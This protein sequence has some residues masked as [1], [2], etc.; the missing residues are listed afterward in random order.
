[1]EDSE[2]ILKLEKDVAEHTEVLQVLA[3]DR[4]AL[5]AVVRALAEANSDNPAFQQHLKAQV[6]LRASHQLNSTMTDGQIALFKE[7]LNA[8]LPPKLRDI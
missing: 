2:K 1:M 5:T 3:A 7:S 4:A 8:L 6:E